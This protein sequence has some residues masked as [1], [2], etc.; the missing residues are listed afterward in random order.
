MIWISTPLLLVLQYFS[1]DND[2]FP[3]ERNIRSFMI[4][5]F[6]LVF[7]LPCLTYSLDF[8]GDLIG[9]FSK[10]KGAQGRNKD[11]EANP[12]GEF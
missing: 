4:A 7:A 1:A 8:L 5:L 3:F 11:S 6:V 2:I 9:K 12:T 10:R